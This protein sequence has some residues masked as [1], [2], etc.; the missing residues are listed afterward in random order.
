MESRKIC[1][2]SARGCLLLVRHDTDSE[3]THVLTPHPSLLKLDLPPEA[4]T[5]AITD[6]NH[7]AHPDYKKNDGAGLYKSRKHCCRL[8]LRVLR[9]KNQVSCAR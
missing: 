4:K 9:A 6:T 2:P 1:W 8:A 3:S 5:L 7:L